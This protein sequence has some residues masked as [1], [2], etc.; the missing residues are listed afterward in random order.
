MVFNTT[1]K[2]ISWSVLLVEKTGL[3]EE[4]HQPVPSQ[5]TDKLH[6]IRLHRVHLAMNEA[7]TRNLS[8]DRHLL[9]S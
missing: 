3:P 7:R 5:V 4:N 6:H 2:N 8:G 1:F 9:H